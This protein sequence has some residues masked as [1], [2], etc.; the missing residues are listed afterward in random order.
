[1]GADSAVKALALQPDGRILVGGDFHTLGGQSRTGIGRL[2]EDGSI[3]FT[4]NDPGL[5]NSV[6][7]IALQSNGKILIGGTFTKANNGATTRNRVARLNADGSVDTSF[8]PGAGANAAV[9]A[10]A[11]QPDGKVLVG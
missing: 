9:R 7:A 4:F 11:L 8:D 6:Y 3:D 10:V 1:P 5:D 2:N